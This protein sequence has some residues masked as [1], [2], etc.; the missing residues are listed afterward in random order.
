VVRKSLLSLAIL[1]AMPVVAAS[2]ADM[3]LKAPP[4]A[5]PAPFSWTGFYFGGEAGYGWGTQQVT[6]VTGATAFP[7]GFVDQPINNINGALGGIYAGYNYQFNPSFLVGVD[8]DIT[9]ASLNGTGT[10]VSPVDGNIA[11]HLTTIDWVS[12]ATGRLGY[13]AGNWLFFGKGGWAWSRWGDSAATNTPAGALSNTS[14]SDSDRQGWTAGG[15]VEWAYSPH[16][17]LKAE[18]DYVDF[19]TAHYT[20]TVNNFL[21]AAAGTNTFEARSTTSSLNIVKIGVAYHF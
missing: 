11:H 18:Y 10:D 20:T 6:H 2:A 13:V 15:G 3:P 21:G 12:T 5:A 17:F 9:W 14:N 7:T 8:A 19:K 1:A 4:P 16:V